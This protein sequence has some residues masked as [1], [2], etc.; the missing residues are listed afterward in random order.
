MSSNS[1]R[2]FALALLGAALAPVVARAADDDAGSADLMRKLRGAPGQRVGGATRGIHRD[3]PAHP[4]P[5]PAS[6]RPSAAQSSNAAT[7]NR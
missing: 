5:A 3:D 4:A 7:T 2:L 6:A 1:R